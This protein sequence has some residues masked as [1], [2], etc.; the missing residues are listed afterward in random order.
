MIKKILT[1]I[2]NYTF[3]SLITLINGALIYLMFSNVFFTIKNWNNIEKGVIINTWVNTFNSESYHAKMYDVKINSLTFRAKDEIETKY[4]V[5]DT[6]LVQYKGN[7]NVRILYVNG[8]K[9]GSKIGLFEYISF[10]F[11]II[12]LLISIVFIKNKFKKIKSKRLG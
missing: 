12:L 8:K 11:T 10:F 2:F 7:K 3:I 1:N 5:G 4:A 6:V 9:V